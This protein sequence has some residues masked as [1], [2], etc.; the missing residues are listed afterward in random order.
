MTRLLTI[1]SI[2]L[3]LTAFADPHG[4]KSPLSFS[5]VITDESSKPVSGAIINIEKNGQV[6][7]STKSDINGNFSIKMEG[8]ISRVDELRITVNKKGYKRV[9]IPP[10]EL[11]VEDLQLQILRY[12][13]IPIIKPIGGGPALSI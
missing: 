2:L 6:I 5:G 9:S 11:K 13:P 1:L 10:V 7:Q 12:T 8:Y 4:D 3:S